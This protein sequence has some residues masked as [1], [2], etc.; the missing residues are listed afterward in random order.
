MAFGGD[1]MTLRR[2]EKNQVDGDGQTQ[3]DC[4]EQQPMRA[5][6]PVLSLADQILSKSSAVV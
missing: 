6:H 1:S 5:R 3:T 4:P 2:A